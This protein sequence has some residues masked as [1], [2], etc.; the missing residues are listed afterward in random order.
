MRTNGWVSD[1]PDAMSAPV[2]TCQPA[3]PRMFVFGVPEL[4]AAG[5]P[6]FVP[7]RR[8]QLLAVLA[9]R[10][11]QWMTRD[12][13]AA[14][15]W[16]ERGNADARRN[17]RHVIF[18]ARGLPG[19][20]G[21]EAT[22]HALRWDVATDLRVFEAALVDGNWLEAIDW[23]RGS[24]LE[25]IDDPANTALAEWL[26]AERARIDALWRHAAHDALAVCS[27]PQHRID[28]AQRLLGLDPLD[29]TALAAVL[30][31]ELALGRKATAQQRY[32]EYAHRLADELGVEP[33]HR[34]R[35]LLGGQNA[36]PVAVGAAGTDAADDTGFVGRRVELA[37]LARL[38][39][40]PGCRLVTIV[41]PG[42]IGKS[43]L[44][45]HALRAYT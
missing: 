28:I 21:I 11:G 15:L 34:L 14:L 45:A 35:D 33:S 39:A 27:T 44:A 24:V 13:L 17:L 43:R 20:E 36:S 8:F 38:L 12:E 26:A 37:E 1:I 5:A 31:A 32:R 23:R 19:A 9:M 42:G 29:E 30:Q 22:E 4:R 7:E 41:G 6:P 18:K 3:G 40:Q 16:P 25:G 10:A 2:P